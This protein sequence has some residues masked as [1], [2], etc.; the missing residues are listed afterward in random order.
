MLMIQEYCNLIGRECIITNNLKYCV[1]NWGKSC[2]SF[3]TFFNLAMQPRPTKGTP[4]KFE[5]VWLQPTKCNTLRCYLYVAS[6]CK[7]SLSYPLKPS[8]DINGQ[9]NPGWTGNFAGGDLLSYGGNLRRS[10]FENWI[11]SK[12]KNSILWILNI[13]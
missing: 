9:R 10:E 5:H 2:F 1:L 8:R 4:G 11:L 7:K 13:N 12:A 6:P 3:A